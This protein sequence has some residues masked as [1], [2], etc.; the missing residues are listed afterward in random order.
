V[1]CAEDRIYL[2][3]LADFP[4]IA[5]EDGSP[6]EDLDHDARGTPDIYRGAVL[7][8][9]EQQLRGAIPDGDDT[10]RVIEL[11]PF[12]IEAG[13]TEISQLEYTI[14][15]H[16]DIGGFDVSMQN[17]TL[18]KIIK[19][20][21]ELLGKVFPVCCLELE[22]RVVQ[23][24]R[25]IMRHVFEDHVALIL[26]NHHFQQSNDVDVPQ[27]LKQLDLSDSCDRETVSLALHSYPLQS[28]KFLG[29]DM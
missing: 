19:T 21:E 28:N 26:L 3:Q 13:Q 4:A 25:Q 29:V 1:W 14:G 27:G 2:V 11:V 5:R 9:S 20:F 15:T 6:G 18:M 10:V 24:A 7:G 23:D 8:L 12:G 22:G 17:A 16:Q